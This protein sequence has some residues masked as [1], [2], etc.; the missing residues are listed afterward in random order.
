VPRNDLS[1]AIV[2]VDPI[3]AYSRR[4]NRLIG[5][6]L[7]AQKS[8]LRRIR[9]HFMT[10]RRDAI[11]VMAERFPMNR[12]T[13][14]GVLNSMNASIAS[15]ANDVGQTVIAGLHGEA[16]IARAIARAYGDAFLPPGSIPALAGSNAGALDIASEF[17]AELIGVEEGGLSFGMQRAVDRE[18]RLAVLG[19]GEGLVRGTETILARLDGFRKF[20]HEAERIYR[21]EVLR[22]NSLITE[23][24][25][26][27]LDQVTPTDKRWIWSGISRPE[28][29]AV[30]GQTVRPAAR[31]KVPLR[32]GGTAELK[33]PRDPSAPPSATINCGCYEIPWPR[34][35]K[36]RRPSSTA[37]TP[38][39]RRPPIPKKPTLKE[40]IGKLEAKIA[41][42]LKAGQVTQ[43]LKG[44]NI[45]RKALAMRDYAPRLEAIAND[46]ERVVKRFPNMANVKPRELVLSKLR[47]GQHQGSR[48]EV[49]AVPGM[50]KTKTFTTPDG[51]TISRRWS[52]VRDGDDHVADI[53]RHE[54]GHHVDQELGITGGATPASAD[55]GLDWQEILGRY[56]IRSTTSVAGESY[57][58]GVLSFWGEN[59]GEYATRIYSWEPGKGRGV[60]AFAE[61]FGM[62]TRRG[63]KRGTLPADVEGF[64]DK[65]L[66]AKVG[67]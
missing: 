60:E 25:I 9:R 32:D 43:Y 2:E 12:A 21:T 11:R 66:G 5:R 18:L 8:D 30:H 57:K 23:R 61:L 28:H 35:T 49:G 17:S 51:K 56:P 20:Q 3:E 41:E 54:F 39:K 10:F 26:R 1:F 47:G 63:Y 24:N 34:E 19:A 33:F 65:V 42:R 59:F 48:I 64:M 45:R 37:T 52:Q 6:G 62:V 44:Q 31:F 58:G 4:V 29:Q 16:E 55:L 36:K 14:G 38:R 67:D 27:Q 13:L 7:K 50:N 22:V 15:L 46:W 40:R 53:F